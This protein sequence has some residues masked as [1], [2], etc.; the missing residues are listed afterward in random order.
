M[1]KMDR[2]QTSNIHINSMDDIHTYVQFPR[3]A[4]VPGQHRTSLSTVTEY[5]LNSRREHNFF[6]SLFEYLILSIAVV[7]DKL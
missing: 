3:I 1:V 6:F 2:R 4:D 5:N 7:H